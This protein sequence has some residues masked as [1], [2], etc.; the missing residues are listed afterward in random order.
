MTCC[1]VQAVGCSVMV[2]MNDL[3]SVVKKDDEDEEDSA[4]D[5]WYGPS[6]TP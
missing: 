1:A 5:G 2:E 6:W 3:P 4:G